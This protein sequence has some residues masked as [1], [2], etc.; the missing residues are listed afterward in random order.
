MGHCGGIWGYLEKGPEKCLSWD[1]AVGALN[2]LNL[3][4]GLGPHMF[5]D[6]AC[7]KDNFSETTRDHWGIDINDTYRRGVITR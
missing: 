2:M 1:L 6:G 5:P 4:R 3:E 7:A